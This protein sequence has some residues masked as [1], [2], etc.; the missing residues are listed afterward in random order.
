MHD[1]ILKAL[2]SLHS[3]SSE[4]EAFW[5]PPRVKAHSEI[6]LAR[7]PFEFC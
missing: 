2:S 5:L 3:L 1:V 4:E 6:S 7:I